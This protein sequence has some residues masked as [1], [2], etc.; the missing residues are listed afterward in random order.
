MRPTATLTAY[1]FPLSACF[2][3][4]ITALTLCGCG[5]GGRPTLP[6]PAVNVAVVNPV[7]TAEWQ[8]FSGQ[9]EGVESAEVRPRVA[10]YIERVAYEEGADVK[11]GSPL[12][13]IDDREFKAAVDVASANVKRA[14]ARLDVATSELKRTEALAKTDAA[15]P[16]ELEQRRSEA[17]QASADHD[18]AVAQLKT[19]QLNLEFAHV[20][21]P[22]DGRAGKAE[23]RAGNLVVANTTLL[24]SVVRLDPIY[25]NFAVDEQSFLHMR[26]AG[27]HAKIKVMSADD[28]AVHEGSL[29]FI[30][31][32]IDRLSGTVRLR[33]Q[34]SNADHQ[35]LPGLIVNVSIEA[36][37]PAP[38]LLI[39]ENAIQT[40]QD[41][42]FVYVVNEHNQAIR[43]DVKLGAHIDNL[44]SV[45]TGLQAGDKVVVDGTRKIFASGQ[46]VA[47]SVVDMQHPEGGAATAKP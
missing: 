21:A 27:P 26:Q 16:S 7:M 22:F 31:N 1:R 37:A 41:R 4:L 30:D 33:G 43:K 25:V 39:A 45:T 14:I 11:K 24:T 19:A 46:P 15:S 40:D 8:S 34:I 18:S 9:L 12:F 28:S 17:V 20:S 13:I 5:G 47:P 42:Q 44:V 35:L 10:G 3:S 23:V 6:P 38:H 36:S 2:G 29:N 32:Q